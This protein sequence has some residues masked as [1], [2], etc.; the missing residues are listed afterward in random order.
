[1]RIETSFRTPKETEVSSSVVQRVFSKYQTAPSLFLNK[2]T[3]SPEYVPGE[4]LHREREMEQLTHMMAPVLRDYSPNNIFIYGSVGTGK[5]ITAKFVLSEL[6]KLVRKN[7]KTHIIYINCKMRRVSDTEYRLLSQMLK[8]FGV[9]V[10]DTGLS[11][12][13]LHRRLEALLEGKNT[14]VVLDEVD[15]LI[16]KIGD[17][18]LYSMIRTA[19]NLSLIGITNNLTWQKRLD[20]RVV[21]SLREEEIVFNKYNALQLYDI[22][23]ARAEEAFSIKIYDAVINKCAALAAQ[24]H[25]DAR[26]ALTLLRLAGDLA[27]REGSPNVEEYHVDMAEQKMDNDKVVESLKGMPRQ[28]QAVFA[29][30]LELNN[31]ILRASG[32]WKDNRILSGDVYVKYKEI[33]RLLQIRNLTQRRVCDLVKEIESM[34]LIETNVVSHGRHGRKTEIRLSV[35]DSLISRAQVVLAEEGFL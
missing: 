6:S 18:F 1:M 27:E 34:G 14:V 16:Q 25:G 17:N 28:S 22:L 33:C 20:M 12:N 23:K 4:I 7:K 9:K 29:A 3:L 5:T 24:E 8:E 11:T 30:L 15:T 2:N 21:S 35:E 31:R 19:D 10:P 13:V 26:R 32:K